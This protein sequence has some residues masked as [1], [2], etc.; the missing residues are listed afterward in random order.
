M[1][2]KEKIRVLI[3][4]VLNRRGDLQPFG[5][6]DS[7]IF[8]GRTDSLNVLEIVGFLEREF[9]FEISEMDF[10]QTQFDSVDSI[11]ALV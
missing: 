9:Q 10:D 1:E 3:R 8:S 4:D 6:G 11:A 5:D 7:L 2:G